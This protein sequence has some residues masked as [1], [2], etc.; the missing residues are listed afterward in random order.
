MRPR[1]LRRRPLR[2]H[3]PHVGIERFRPT[4][5]RPRR[6]RP[7]TRET[8]IPPRFSPQRHRGVPNQTRQHLLRDHRRQRRPVHL[9]VRRL[10]R[11]RRRKVGARRRRLAPRP[12]VGRIARGGRVLRLPGRGR[13]A[14]HDGPDDRGGDPDLRG[15]QL[16]PSR[17]F[18][19]GRSGPPRTCRDARGGGGD[20]RLRRTRLHPRPHRRRR[21][22]LLGTQRQGTAGFGRW[23]F[24]GHLRHGGA[25]PTRGGT[26][27]GTEGEE[28]RG[29]TQ[30]RGGR[31]G[32]RGAVRVGEQRVFGTAAVSG[33]VAF[34]DNR[35]SLRRKFHGGP[36]RGRPTLHLR[37]GPDR[38]PRS[39][40]QEERQPTPIGRGVG[41]QG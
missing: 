10:G 25:A 30:P 27:G 21:R 7:S 15:G 24:R 5:T 12:Q 13:R 17:E 8:P 32:R 2:R 41:R 11:Q 33:V 31:D 19:H 16:R 40:V 14:S 38:L 36:R 3:L 37:E 4:G 9:R 1:L 6:R 20:F 35:R 18:G 26:A 28:G 22:S 34:E 23:T 29:G 39:R